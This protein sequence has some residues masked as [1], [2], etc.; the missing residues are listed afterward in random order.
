M[1]STN[2]PLQGAVNKRR[3]KTLLTREVYDFFATRREAPTSAD[4][5][6]LQEPSPRPALHVQDI[7]VD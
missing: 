5:E 3:P 1:S 6:C 4:C 2:S 7:D